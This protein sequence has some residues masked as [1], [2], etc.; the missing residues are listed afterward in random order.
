LDPLKGNPRF[1]FPVRFWSEVIGLE[2]EPL[3]D[4]L[5]DLGPI[6][7]KWVELRVYLRQRNDQATFDRI[8]PVVQGIAQL[9][10]NT[11]GFGD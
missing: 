3:I 7:S 10:E 11:F 4:R 9:M 5:R 2:A 6:E 8:F 1:S